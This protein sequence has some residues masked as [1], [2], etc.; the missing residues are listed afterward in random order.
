[1]NDV[2]AEFVGND[3]VV[4]M[5]QEEYEEI[6]DLFQSRYGISL[7]YAIQQ[8]IM[9]IVNNRHEFRQWIEKVS[10]HNTFQK[11]KKKGKFEPRK[12]K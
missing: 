9:W 2:S 4:T 7:E 8:Y 12:E 11:P 6:E 3:L 1:M 10:A 5:P